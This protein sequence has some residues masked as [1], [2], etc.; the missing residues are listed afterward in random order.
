MSELIFTV[1]LLI[2]GEGDSVVLAEKYPKK[3][4]KTKANFKSV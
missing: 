4:H 2:E 1:T 3:A